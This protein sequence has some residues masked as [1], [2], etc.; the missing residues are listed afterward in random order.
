M[1]ARIAELV[2]GRVLRLDFEK[3]VVVRWTMD[4]W[5]TTTD[6]VAIQVRPGLWVVEVLTAGAEVGTVVRFTVF[7]EEAKQWLGED[8][9]VEVAPNH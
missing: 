4:E 8:F 1:D 9:F 2:V 5:H 7:W 3:A 6:S